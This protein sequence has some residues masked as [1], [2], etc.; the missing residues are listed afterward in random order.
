MSG[1]NLRKLKLYDNNGVDYL[2]T[3]EAN[4]PVTLRDSNGLVLKLEDNGSV[5]VTLQD[6][7]TPPIVIPFSKTNNVTSLSVA[8]AVDDYTIT[9]ATTTGFVDGSFIIISNVTTERYWFGYQ[10]G[11]PAGNIITVDRPLDSIFPIG[12]QVTA[13]STNL[14]VNGSISLGSEVFSIRQNDLGV[15]IT[16]DITRFM[17]IIYADTAV[18]LPDFGDITGG[19]TYGVSMRR[20]D[21]TYQN[22]INFKTNGELINFAFDN[23]F[24]EA[25]NPAQGQD[26]LVVRLTTAG[27]NKMGVVTRIGPLE[28]VEVLI[29]DDL[30]SLPFF[31]IIAEGSQAIVD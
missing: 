28:D 27:Q 13:G 31:Q 25:I 9:I 19:L 22:F 7:T 20:V 14:N 24:Y 3:T 8:T 1:A 10:V 15:P 16:L 5:P 26:G 18:T 30:T 21:G 4:A 23:A 17:F 29:N 2:F 6:Q 11:A 12:T